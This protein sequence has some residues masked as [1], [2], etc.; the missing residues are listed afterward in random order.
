MAE[1]NKGGRPNKLKADDA[2]VKIVKGLGNIQATSKEC[3]AVLG[4][5][6]PTWI[7]FK[8]DNPEI[9]AALIEGQGEGLASLRRRQFKAAN[10][11]N[12]TMLVWL[13]KQ[14]LGQ[15]DKQEI[16]STVQ[17]EV[18]DARNALEHLITRNASARSNQGGAGATH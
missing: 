2:T 6:E 5:T 8:K 3:A 9:E 11:G 10:D 1:K 13:G 17:V 16:A 7:K 4:V 15:S 14:Y 18:T 12:A